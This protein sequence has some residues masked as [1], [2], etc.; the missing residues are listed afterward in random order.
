MTI[1]CIHGCIEQDLDDH[2]LD[3]NP[4]NPDVNTTDKYTALMIQTH[5]MRVLHRQQKMHQKEGSP[6]NKLRKPNCSQKDPKGEERAQKKI[7][8]WSTDSAGLFKLSKPELTESETKVLSKGFS[9]VQGYSY[10]MILI[11]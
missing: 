5:P 2:H 1:E 4:N 3:I 11:L 10:V 9:F 6:H 8:D 7:T